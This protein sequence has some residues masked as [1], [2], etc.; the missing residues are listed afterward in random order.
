MFG[1]D[2]T[3]RVGNQIDYAA[4]SRSLGSSYIRVQDQ[5][6]VK[7]ESEQQKQHD[8]DSLGGNDDVQKAELRNKVQ[9]LTEEKGRL[10]F[11]GT[12]F[13]TFF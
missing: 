9:D 2:W 6:I 11:F 3:G 4:P 13:Q 1:V 12:F 7:L 8:R 5:Q 10:K